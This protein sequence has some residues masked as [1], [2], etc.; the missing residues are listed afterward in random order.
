MGCGKYPHQNP[1]LQLKKTIIFDPRV[2]SWGFLLF[3]LI[4]FNYAKRQD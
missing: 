3:D 2:L 4:F 1:I